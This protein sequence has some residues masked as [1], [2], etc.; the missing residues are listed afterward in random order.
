VIQRA[1]HLQEARL[2]DSYLAERGGEPIDPPVAEHLA[3]CAACSARYAELTAFMDGLRRDGEADAD[4]VFTPERLRVQQQQIARRIALL[5]RPARVLS[6]PAP[7]VWRNHDP[8]AP[9]R[10]P[11][12]VAAAAAAGLFIGVAA[13][14]SFQ[15]RSQVQSRQSFVSDA[16]RVRAQR[17][18]PVATRGSGAAEVAN[19]DAFLS[20]LETALERPHT[21]E[22]QAFDELTPHIREIRDQR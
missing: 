19:D 17:V 8:A 15:W 3:D 13:G 14:A 18:T 21:R 11:R 2:F 6:F 4:A 10:A 9:R 5:G 1:H 22:L 7:P 20:D 12:W 16:G